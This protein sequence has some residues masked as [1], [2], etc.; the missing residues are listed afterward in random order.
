MTPK[1]GS[2]RFIRPGPVFGRISAVDASQTLCLSG[3]RRKN[4]A[5][6]QVFGGFSVVIRL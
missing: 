4:V 6:R 2:A 3:M 1:S 5:C